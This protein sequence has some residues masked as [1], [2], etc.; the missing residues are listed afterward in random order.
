MT[1]HDYLH[2]FITRQF[3][4][5]ACSIGVLEVMGVYGASSRLFDDSC[6]FPRTP[7][8]Q[9]S[10]QWHAVYVDAGLFVFCTDAINR[11]ADNVYLYAV[12]TLALTEVVNILFSTSPF[13]I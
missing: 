7:K 11:F 3:S 8:V 9:C 4:G 5:V 2:F 1:T 13:F 12:S 10:S 6:Q